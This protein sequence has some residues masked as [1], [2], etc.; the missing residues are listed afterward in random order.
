LSTFFPNANISE[1][2]FWEF[3]RERVEL[4]KKLGEGH[5]GSVNKARILPIY[6]LD[7]MN[8]GIVAVKMI[9]GI[10]LQRIVLEWPG[11]YFMHNYFITNYLHIFT[12]LS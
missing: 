10:V 2:Q 4:L 11:I 1:E 6:S 7:L 8:A 12:K 3:P 9:K 5:F